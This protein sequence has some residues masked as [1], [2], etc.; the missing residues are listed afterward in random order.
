MLVQWRS[1][2]SRETWQAN[3][4]LARTL[5]SCDIEICFSLSK[6][7]FFASLGSDQ[8]DGLVKINFWRLPLLFD[9]ELGVDDVVVFFIFFVFGRFIGIF[10]GC[11]L[12]CGFFVH[13]FSE[14][15]AGGLEVFH[16]SADG[17]GVVRFSG[18]F[19]SVDG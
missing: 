8:N 16:G 6:R 19:E 12:L 9:F 7:W 11:G 10:G 5:G 14:G 18:V 4:L 13:D 1:W 3:S 17:F 2:A 15:L